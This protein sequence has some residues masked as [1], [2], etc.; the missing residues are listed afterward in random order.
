VRITALRLA[1]F[2]VITSPN[3]VPALSGPSQVTVTRVLTWPAAGQEILSPQFSPDG[4]FIALVTRS[5]IPDGGDAEGLPRSFFQ[6]IEKQE[7][8][9]PRFADPVIKVIDL[10]GNI[11]CT[12]KYGW[13]PSLAPDNEHLV[14]A[15]QVK[16]ITGFRELA[17][18][19]AGNGIR[20]YSCATRQTVNVADP[21]TGYLDRPIFSLDGSSI[22]Y[23]MNEAVNGAYGGAVG[24][25]RFDLRQHRPVT[26]LDKHIVP[27]VP[28]PPTGSQGT[29]PGICS[30][31]EWLS[32]SF[33]GIV[34]GI[35]S[36]GNEVIALIGRPIPALG[37]IY[38]ARRYDRSLVSVFPAQR[39]ILSLGPMSGLDPTALQAVS[40]ERVMVFSKYWKLFSTSSGQPLPD[41][42]PKNSELNSSYSPD[43]KYYL[44]AEAVKPDQDLFHFVLYR[45]SDGEKLAS[46]PRMTA[47]YAAVWSPQA[48][49]FAIIGIAPT[50]ASAA[51]HH[52]EE[53]LIYS[54][55]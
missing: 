19:M 18:P 5:Y 22:V 46:L 54:I 39:T 26:L 9:N 50:G 20:M 47:P 15:E 23:T 28:C 13:N 33:S 49:R 2:V 41:V 11:T 27:A 1:L 38:L 34:Y 42:G 14:F 45:K 51:R 32:R 24:I 25:A 30:H 21:R 43:L 53:L 55:R 12:A 16:P 31:P 6:A 8:A 10:H 36:A 52:V 17:S 40:N 44:R 29:T 48:N 35:S 3:P 4:D 37:D 7:K